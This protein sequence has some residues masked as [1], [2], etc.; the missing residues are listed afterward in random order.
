MEYLSLNVFFAS[1]SE[2]G[3]CGVDTEDSTRPRRFRQTM[4]AGN[5]IVA[6]PKTRTAMV[7]IASTIVG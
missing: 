4:A 7:G 5:E 6:T 2:V 1:R 3:I